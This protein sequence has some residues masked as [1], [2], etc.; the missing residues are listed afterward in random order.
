MS[1]ANGLN[2]R[3]VEFFQQSDPVKDIHGKETGE[4]VARDYVK[5]GPPHLLDRQV[6]TARVDRILKAKRPVQGSKNP[7]EL[8]AWLRAEYI[9]PMYEAWKRGEELPDNGTPLAVLNFLR[10]EDV[11]L[12]KRHGIRSVQELST[13]HEG[14]FDR[15]PV[16]GLR[17]KKTQAAKFLE[18]QDANKAAAEMAKR[19][20]KIAELERKLAELAASRASEDA[21]VDE[22][23]DR[24]P[25]RRGRPPKVEQH[26][27][28]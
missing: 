13:L 20:D 7:H 25:K 1:E 26:E 14:S 2:I 23:G 27:A 10:P 11:A 18:A 19:D 5:Y 9:R 4:L 3:V 8:H 24:I 15:I 22:N 6:V 12:L 17:E 28:A 16:P 21:E